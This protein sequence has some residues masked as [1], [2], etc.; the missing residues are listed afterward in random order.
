MFVET[1][2]ERVTGEKDATVG[3]FTLVME[4]GAPSSSLL[5]F[6]GDDIESSQGVSLRSSQLCSEG[7][8]ASVARTMAA[9][10]NV[11]ARNAPSQVGWWY[12]ILSRGIG[13]A[14]MKDESPSANN[15]R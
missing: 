13:R 11:M 9:I 1:A 7:S 3:R 12:A 15:A 6:E 14:I 10:Y 2:C 4:T 8:V 5:N